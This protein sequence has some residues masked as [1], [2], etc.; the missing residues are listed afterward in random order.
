M[1]AYGHRI[2]IGP[3]DV[4]VKATLQYENRDYLNVT[5]SV[6]EPRRDERLRAGINST[7]QISE[8]FGITGDV[9]YADNRSNLASANF[10][11]MVYTL[12]VKLEY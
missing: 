8:Y 3:V 10:D 6:G 5:E 4:G 1:L 9:D 7:I 12:G 2:E 11:E